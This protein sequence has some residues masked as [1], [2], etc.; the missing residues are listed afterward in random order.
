MKQTLQEKLMGPKSDDSPL[1]FVALCFFGL[2]IAGLLF[3][4]LWAW[5]MRDGLGPDST[6][7]RGWIAFVRFVTELGWS[8]AVPVALLLIGFLIYRTDCASD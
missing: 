7:S 8:P 5:A 6:E 4:S 1:L 2:G 3:L